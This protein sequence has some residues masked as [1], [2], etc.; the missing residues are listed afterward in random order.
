MTQ[1]Q[2]VVTYIVNPKTNRVHRAIDGKTYENCNVDQLT[3]RVILTQEQYDAFGAKYVK[4]V[5][6]FRLGR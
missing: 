5:R 1:E 4:C 2:H 3:R 6:C